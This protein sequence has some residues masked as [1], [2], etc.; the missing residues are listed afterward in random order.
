[1]QL[2]FVVVVV[3]WFKAHRKKENKGTTGE[4]T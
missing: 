3:F 2:A 1:M 4:G